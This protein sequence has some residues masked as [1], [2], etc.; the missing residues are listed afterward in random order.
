MI[1]LIGSRAMQMHF[2]DFRDVKNADWDFQ[3]DTAF[4]PHTMW[5]YGFPVMPGESLDSFVDFRLMAWPWGKV[6][7]PDELYT[8][9]VSHGYWE[10]G[11]TWE[12]HAS[13]IVFLKRKGAQFLPEL[14]D[15]LLEIWRERY[16]ANK[17]SLKKTGKEF[18]DDH[19]QKIY[20]HDSVHRSVAYRDRP[21]YEDILLPG[22]EVLTDKA[23]FLAMNLPDQLDL[24]REEL[25]V[26]AL[27]RKLI[28]MNYEGSPMSAYKWALRRLCT[29]LFKNE[30]AT[31]VLRNLDELG[32]PDIDYVKR[33]R[34]NCGMLIPYGLDSETTG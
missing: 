30:W 4:D 22:E 17:I 21:W 11:N 2:P 26:I 7:T 33:H 29:S 5:E 15:L 6:A 13:D 31:F 18:F 8:M 32:K 34:D 27:E 24:V 16:K 19:V 14:H 10:I 9:K 12:K 20:D 25:Y 1:T 23:K 28:P 3:S